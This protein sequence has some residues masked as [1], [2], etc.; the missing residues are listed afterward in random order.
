VPFHWTRISS[1]TAKGRRDDVRKVCNKPEYKGAGLVADHVFTAAPGELFV[2]VRLP[3]DTGRH[4]A[5]LAD[6]KAEKGGV[7]LTDTDGN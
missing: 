6:I 3:D 4:D 1:S 5:F 2:L 7:N